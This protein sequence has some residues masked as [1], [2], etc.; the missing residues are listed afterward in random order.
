VFCIQRSLQHRK[1]VVHAD[2]LAPFREAITVRNNELQAINPI[3]F[4]NIF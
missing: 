2:R 1:K 4:F 3:N